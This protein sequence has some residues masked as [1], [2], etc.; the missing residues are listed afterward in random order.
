[1]VLDLRTVRDDPDRARASQRLRGADES[2][3]DVLLA[4]DEARRAA[5]AR[6]DSLRAEQRTI[7]RS[8]SKAN[9]D[10]RPA[11]R[12]KAKTLAAEVRAAEVEQ[13]VAEQAL[14][15]AQF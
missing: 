14:R 10:E 4:A 13:D 6:A 5:V 8:V 1:M 3:V 15:E 12:D 11:L 9:A 7:G 2:L